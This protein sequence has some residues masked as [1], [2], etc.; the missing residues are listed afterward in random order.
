MLFRSALIALCAAA[1]PVAAKDLL[2][3]S[4]SADRELTLN[5]R[6]QGKATDVNNECFLTCIIVS[7]LMLLTHLYHCFNLYYRK[8]SQS[9][10]PAA[11][12]GA[13]CQ[14]FQGP[15]S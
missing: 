15:H 10:C 13:C 3:G 12:V 4:A 5:S 8:Q 6:A 2:R 11:A 7:L 14:H 1:T 9:S